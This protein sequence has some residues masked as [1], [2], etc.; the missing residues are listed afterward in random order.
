MEKLLEDSVPCRVRAKRGCATHPR[1]IAER[2]QRTQ[3][4][5][6]IRK[7]Q[8]LIPNMDKVGYILRSILIEKFKFNM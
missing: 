2:V 1:S 7:L 5:D 4:S 8:E 6:R 3:I